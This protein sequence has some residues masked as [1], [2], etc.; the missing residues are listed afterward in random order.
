M[1]RIRLQPSGPPYD[2]PMRAHR[3]RRK[4]PVIARGIQPPARIQAG[5]RGTVSFSAGS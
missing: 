2:V 1:A 4:K 5:M 3:R